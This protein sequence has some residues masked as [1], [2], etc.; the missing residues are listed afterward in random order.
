ML[1]QKYEVHLPSL[2]SYK[3]T[4]NNRIKCHGQ[5][6]YHYLLLQCLL[7]FFLLFVLLLELR[8]ETPAA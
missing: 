6:V 2:K 4:Q 1:R 8:K 7:T 3:Q 5:K